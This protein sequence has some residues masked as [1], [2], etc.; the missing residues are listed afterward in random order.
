[1]EVEVEDDEVVVV[2]E[3]APRSKSQ[4]NTLNWLLRVTQTS[5]PCWRPDARV[6]VVVTSITTHGNEAKVV[7]EV[8]V[9]VMNAML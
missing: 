1:M 3:V 8:V 4:I 9:D 5:N 6:G 2:V 7:V